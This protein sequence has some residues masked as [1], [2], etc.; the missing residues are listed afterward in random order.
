MVYSTDGIPGVEA[1]AAQEGVAPL[2]SFKLKQEY[3]EL[4]GFVRARMSLA[5]VRSNSVLLCIP[6][7]K[8][9]RICQRPELLGG[10][11]M[12]LLVP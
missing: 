2:I 3:S 12:A 11:V 6:W 8:E 5:T 4:C 1:L 7:D 9:A 10:V